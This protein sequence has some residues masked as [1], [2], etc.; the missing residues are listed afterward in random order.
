MFASNHV[1]D[2]SPRLFQGTDGIQIGVHHLFVLYC[3]FLCPH[4]GRHRHLGSF[5][6]NEFPTLFVNRVLAFV[7]CLLRVGSLGRMIAKEFPG[8]NLCLPYRI[9]DELNLVFFQFFSVHR[10]RFQ[11]AFAKTG[12]QGSFICFDLFFLWQT[13]V[14]ELDFVHV[15]ACEF[16]LVFH[17]RIIV[18]R[19]PGLKLFLR[20]ITSQI[21]HDF[22]PN[23]V[24][25]MEFLF[26][27]DVPS[28]TSSVGG[29]SCYLEIFDFGFR[30]AVAH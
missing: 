7:V 3:E 28:K 18:G 8:I 14:L 11:S 19:K 6:L 15:Y 1:C 30:A 29:I 13:F 12:G 20:G 17:H 24:V 16:A 2:P 26:W 21:V 10:P 5:L 25:P 4:R 22:H 27:L 9:D 23:T